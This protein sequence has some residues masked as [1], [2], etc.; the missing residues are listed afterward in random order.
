MSKSR[1][2][3]ELDSEYQ[4]FLECDLHQMTLRLLAPILM[5]LTGGSL[6]DQKKLSPI[7]SSIGR[8][9]NVFGLASPEW[10]NGI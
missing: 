10:A 8:L 9:I 4:E 7:Q 1:Q 2:D 5:N 6:C 3:K